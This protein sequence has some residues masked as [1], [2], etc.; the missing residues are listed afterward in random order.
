MWVCYYQQWVRQ[1]M[2]VPSLAKKRITGIYPVQCLYV[3]NLLAAVI[4]GHLIYSGWTT[5][6][7][8]L[9]FLTFPT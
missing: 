6:K 2:K 9:I 7:S 3:W 5:S 1:T 8:L 4:R